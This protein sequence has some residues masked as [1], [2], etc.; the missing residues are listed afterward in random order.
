MDPSTANGPEKPACPSTGSP[1][2]L[3]VLLGLFIVWQIIY[4]VAGNLLNMAQE[5]RSSLADPDNEPKLVQKAAEV[6]Q[7]LAP[8]WIKKEGH[9]Y[10]ADEA[11]SGLTK[12]WGQITGQVQGWSL[13]APSVSEHN[14]FVAV[15]LR[16]D[17][18]SY[19]PELLLSDNEPR[20]PN[21]FFRLGDFRLRKY[22]SHLDVL[23][24]LHDDEATE[25]AAAERWRLR[26]E[27]KLDTDGKDLLAYLRWR[28]RKFRQAHPDRP[29]PSQVILY[30]RRYSI[31]P[32]EQVPWHW[33]T[34]NYQMFD[35][36]PMARWQPG[37]DWEPDYQA[38][39][40]YN[41]ETGRFEKR[42]QR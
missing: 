8:G 41:H 25:A 14:T 26:I 5:T 20:D 1:S 40:M 28:W 10:D 2:T 27:E 36:Q 12:R 42:R 15:E 22:E 9:V 29:T 11:L 21:C 18:E 37:A 6:V 31:P 24:T 23:L 30:V 38:L 3:Q 7:W 16:W 32:P 4:L 13:F 17:G 35:R 33:D 39:E 19:P 34:N